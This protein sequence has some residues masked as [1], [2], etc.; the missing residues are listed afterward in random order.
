MKLYVKEKDGKNVYINK[1]GSTRTELRDIVGRN[2]FKV[3]GKKY[4]IRDVKASKDSND[5][6]KGVV[7]GGVIGAFAG[8][9][10]IVV[11]SAA[12]AI[13]GNSSDKRRVKNVERFNK[14]QNKWS[15]IKK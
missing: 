10:G 12:G 1:V 14:S 6:F 3:N 2:D 5:T 4:H 13:I 9:L 8:P 15:K 7:V 11:G